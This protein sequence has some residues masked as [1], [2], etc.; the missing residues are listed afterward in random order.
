MSQR[1]KQSGAG[2]LSVEEQ[3]AGGADV[4][5]LISSGALY[6]DYDP[7]NDD[8]YFFTSQEDAA[9]RVIVPM[10]EEE[11]ALA[12]ARADWWHEFY[13]CGKNDS[14]MPPRYVPKEQK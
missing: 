12:E 14:P 13:R 9:K 1:F 10:N 4:D 6:D 7:K 8:G 3:L 5:E 2:D 11:V